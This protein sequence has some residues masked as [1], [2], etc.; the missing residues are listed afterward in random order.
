MV[1]CQFDPGIHVDA[2][3]IPSSRNK[4]IQLKDN[5]SLTQ[6]KQSPRNQLTN[7]CGNTECFLVSEGKITTVNTSSGAAIETLIKN[8]LAN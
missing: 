2:A 1:F 3:A 7:V 4:H 6:S 8:S 5:I